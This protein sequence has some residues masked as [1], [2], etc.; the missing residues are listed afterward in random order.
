VSAAAL[1][2]PAPWPRV[3]RAEAAALLSSRAI[4]LTLLA[5]VLLT[6][7]P[8]FGGQSEWPYSQVRDFAPL[9]FFF[10]LLHW[11]GR[12]GRGSLDQGMPVGAMGYE[13]VRV[14]CGALAAAFTM[15]LATGVHT[16]NMRQVFD[17]PGVLRGFPASYP[18]ALTLTGVAYYLFG[19]ALMLRARRPGRMLV[20]GFAIG[21]TVMIVTRVGLEQTGMHLDYAPD[22]SPTVSFRTSL[23]LAG[24]L[25]WLA[26]GIAAVGLSA[27]LGRREGTAAAGRWFRPRAS[28]LP[29]RSAPAQVP[30]PD[31]LRNP[32][33]ARVV[34]VRQ[35]AVQAPRMMVPLGMAVLLG[36]WSAWRE[37]LG[38]G[39]FL[40]G[41]M[42]LMPFV[43]VAF[44]W[45]LLVWMDE[46]RGDWDGM[47]PVDALTRRLL[48]AAAGL[49]WLQAAVLIVLAGCIGGA[50]A[51]GTLQ[52]LAQVPAWVLPGV[53]LAVLALYLLGTAWVMLSEHPVRTAIIGFLVTIQLL[54]LMDAIGNLLDGRSVLKPT[55]VFAPVN[56]MAP[57]QD[58]RT[59]ATIVWILIFAA[60]AVAAIRRRVRRDLHGAAPSPQAAAP[61]TTPA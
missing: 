36:A 61:R 60:L 51:E 52:S 29:V 7:G 53:P 39:T 15:A 48:H 17:A 26:G 9:M 23:T 2:R 46:R 55:G 13:L 5:V 32:A 54:V 22:G 34:A 35:L 6:A 11:R 59:G 40:S 24:A 58:H 56:F 31:V 21:I 12:A 27:W 28:A 41:G 49:V 50:L 57:V 14:A 10:P 47:L 30:A 4:P 44:F 3:A 19:S 18:L 43:Y 37:T 38:G 45:P 1:R 20:A 8:F 16:W 25:L 33:D 42:P